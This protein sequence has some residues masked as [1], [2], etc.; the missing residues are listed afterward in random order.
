PVDPESQL[1][2]LMLSQITPA[3]LQ[4]KSEDVTTQIADWSTGRSTTPPH[5]SLND[6]QE[7][8]MA[9]SPESQ[10][11][12]NQLLAEL[13][14]A[15]ADQGGQLPQVAEDPESQAAL[16]ELFETGTNIQQLA[17]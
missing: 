9:H 12:L 5:L 14:Q 7:Q 6:L 8:I 2:Q 3:Y 10:A 13:R 4:A 16:E 11:Q 1:S 15:Q 17:D